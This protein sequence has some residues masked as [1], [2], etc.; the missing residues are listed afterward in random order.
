MR[1]ES[2]LGSTDEQLRGGRR[3]EGK[4]LGCVAPR[5]GLCCSVRVCYV[6]VT[7]I[8]VLLLRVCLCCHVYVF[9]RHARVPCDYRKIAARRGETSDGNARMETEPMRDLCEAVHG[10]TRLC[11]VT[12]PRWLCLMDGVMAATR[13]RRQQRARRRRIATRSGRCSQWPD[14]PSV[15]CR[16]APEIHF[17]SLQVTFRVQETKKSQHFRSK[18]F[19]C[20]NF[21]C[22][23]QRSHGQHPSSFLNA[24]AVSGDWS[25]IVRF[26]S[27]NRCQS[28]PTGWRLI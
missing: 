5:V 19:R 25:V 28:V 8:R 23:L 13:R 12:S 18:H 15:C 3:S 1:G 22:T 4:L 11:V 9:E 24:Q 7:C 16:S 10:L 20:Q 14:P 21:W 27:N 26:V 17:G 2:R 6:V